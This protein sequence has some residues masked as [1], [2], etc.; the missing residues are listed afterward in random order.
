M[1]FL[2]NGKLYDIKLNNEILKYKQKS[3]LYLKY[4]FDH[5]TLVKMVIPL[6]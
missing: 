1:K 2:E 4:F 3:K 5:N 6:L